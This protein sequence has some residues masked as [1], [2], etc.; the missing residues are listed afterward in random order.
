MKT[1]QPKD[2]LSLT[3]FKNEKDRQLVFYNK[4]CEIS[5]FFC[6]YETQSLKINKDNCTHKLF[7]H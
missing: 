4:R 1:M 2:T 6:L 7:I 5:V 3:F